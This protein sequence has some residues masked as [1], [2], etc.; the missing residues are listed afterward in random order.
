MDRALEEAEQ[1]GSDSRYLIR[2]LRI[3]TAVGARPKRDAGIHKEFF[4]R[5]LARLEAAGVVLKGIEW[6]PDD[7]RVA[8]FI[9]SV[10]SFVTERYLEL[11]DLGLS[12]EKTVEIQTKEIRAFLE[13]R[14][15]G[16]R[17]RLYRAMTP[18]GLKNGWEA[19]ELGE[20]IVLGIFA[21]EADWTGLGSCQA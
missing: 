9:Y 2:N 21:A 3:F 19:A 5:G 7:W 12:P 14:E 11:A 1:S 6:K 17:G 18:A 16:P 4:D 13:S 8:G 15:D 20:L 10:H